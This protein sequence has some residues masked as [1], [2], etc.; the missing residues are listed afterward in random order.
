MLSGVV[1][2]SQPPICTEVMPRQCSARARDAASVRREHPSS[3]T[4]CRARKHGGE[5]QAR[6][7]ARTQ[8]RCFSSNP[9]AAHLKAAAAP[10]EL[11]DGLVGDL[12]AAAEADRAQARAAI[13]ELG[14]RA[15][16]SSFHPPTAA[17]LIHPSLH[18]NHSSETIPVLSGRG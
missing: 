4:V 14:D 16:A 10:R 13:G 18:S 1:S 12:L 9:S 2:R 7:R 15:L 8:A 3:W 17:L 11:D 5:R 6:A